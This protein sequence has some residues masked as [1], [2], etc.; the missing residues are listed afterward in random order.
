MGKNALINKVIV[1]TL[2]KATL[3]CYAMEVNS[4]RRMPL[5][6]HPI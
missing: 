3:T 1:S 4:W 5:D 2:M 6:G